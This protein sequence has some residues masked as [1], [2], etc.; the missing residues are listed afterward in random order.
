MAV[1]ADFNGDGHPDWVVRNVRTRQ[2]VIGYLNDNVFIGGAFGPTLPA[3][4]G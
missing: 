2:T 3:S 1:V 4:W